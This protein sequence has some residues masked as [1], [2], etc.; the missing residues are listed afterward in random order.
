MIETPALST[1]VFPL[2]EADRCVLCGLCLPHCPT[3]RLTQDENESPRGRITL[4]RAAASGALTLDDAVAAHLSRCLDCR[5]CE[6]VCPSGVP[7]GKLISAGRTLSRPRLSLSGIERAALWLVRHRGA[8]AVFGVL[9]LILRRLK[10][11]ALLNAVF[12]HARLGRAMALLPV[13]S[14]QPTR[15]VVS[16]PL[17]PTRGRIALFPGCLA[18]ALEAQTVASAKNVLSIFGYEV[19]V[20]SNLACCGGL[21]RD[22]GDCETA[23]RLCAHNH[24][25]LK[26]QAGQSIVTLASGCGARL[27]QDLGL[28][29]T[30]V[31]DINDFLSALPIPPTHELAPLAGRVVVQDPCSLRNSL[32]T[33]QS[34]YALLQRIPGLVVEPL[35]GNALCCGGAGLYPL[36]QPALAV[37]LREPKL[38]S[39]ENQK[40]NWLVSANLG[41]ALHLA[42]G[43]RER[44]M[45]LEVIHPVV[46]FE[47]QLR[48]RP[49]A[50][51]A[52]PTSGTVAT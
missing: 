44:C 19:I 12:R 1:S 11:V 9:L 29:S 23:D 18:D 50:L 26:E 8:L 20:P 21:H 46:L 33:E 10:R 6:R 14:A 27:A 48:A 32:R 47:R 28:P 24:A 5:A 45:D 49:V 52:L 7:Y 39:L 3:Y 41:C 4:M 31:K 37:A 17:Q 2:A 15:N 22:A 36:R 34:V 16:T 25:V 51:P 42:A 30:P 43:L 35:P 13:T 40:P 38:V